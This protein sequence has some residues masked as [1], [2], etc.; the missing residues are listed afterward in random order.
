MVVRAEGCEVEVLRHC[1]VADTRYTY[2]PFTQ[3]NESL[4]IE[5]RDE[6]FAK[7]PLGAAR[8][9][10]QLERAGSLEIRT[11]M[12]GR[13]ELP[14]QARGESQLRGDC[15][16]ATHV[17]S[18]ATVGAYRM[19]LL[20]EAAVGAEARAWGAG[21]GAKDAARRQ[22]VAEDGD[23]ARCA[24]GSADDLKPPRG[25]AAVLRIEL[26]PL[27]ST[28]DPATLGGLQCEASSVLVPGHRS[29][30]AI[31][32]P[33]CLDR[34]ETTVEAYAEC[35][36]AGACAAAALRSSWPGVVAAER[37][38]SGELC[39]A[40]QAGRG[41]H[42]VNCVSWTAARDYCRWRGGDLPTD[43]AWTWA[44]RG[45]DQARRYP[46]GDDEPSATHTNACGAECRAWFQAR[47][48]RRKR[49]AFSDPD[50]FAGTA[51]VGSFAEGRGRFGAEDLAGNVAEWVRT[52]GQGPLQRARGGSFL[53]Q[54]PQ[55]LTTFD[56]AEVQGPR[57]DPGIGFRCVYPARA[58]SSRVAP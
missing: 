51:P 27:V 35:A 2:A 36:D 10:G 21:L 30:K 23:P 13:Y 33:F 52:P 45:G 38:V 19:A 26:E 8:L 41:E 57:E 18:A 29:D 7:V 9:L 39:N 15:T 6:L 12:V 14:A 24:R 53:V 54:A 20:R 50:G 22:T 37:A 16:A 4:F 46:W 40:S 32:P 31:E 48:L 5:D 58:R 11:T 44:A 55:W 3:K 47:G 17:V 43:A 34:F 25:C 42:P 49:I 56:V 28:E 1:R